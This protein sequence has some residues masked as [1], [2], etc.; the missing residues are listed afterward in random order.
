MMPSV[1]QRGAVNLVFLILVLIVTLVFAALW[2]VKMQESDKLK[3]E[4]ASLSAEVEKEKATRAWYQDYYGEIAPLVGGGVPPQVPFQPQFIEGNVSARDEAA[5]V[6][7]SIKDALQQLG[8]RVDN[9]VDQP[10]DLVVALETPVSAYLRVRGESKT[11][12]DDIQRLSGELQARDK[13]IADNQRAYAEEKARIQTEN[14]ANFQRLNLQLSE[15]RAT[16]EELQAKVRDS[17]TELDKVREDTNKATQDLTTKGKELEGQVRQMHG[18]LRVK[19]VTEAPDG[20]VLA[21]DPK[22]GM[23]MID[24]TSQNQLRRGTRFKVYETG[25]GNVK[26]HKGWITVID[27]GPTMSEARVDESV[28]GVGAIGSGDWLFNPYFEKEG[29]T[30]FVFLGQLPGRYSRETAEGILRNFGAQVEAAVTTHT[31]FLVL[32]EK[33]DPEGEPLESSADYRNAVL[34]GVEIIRARDLAPFLQM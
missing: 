6:T 16:N 10:A 30:R 3:V 20:K 19:R 32:G 7:K 12:G 1:A 9:P 25:K 18:E 28:P 34:W 5:K 8:Q 15:V 11:K 26:I 22:T 24:V 27:T 29:K 13:T 14:D 21:S 2:F 4:K 31:D 23:V 17:N 33:E